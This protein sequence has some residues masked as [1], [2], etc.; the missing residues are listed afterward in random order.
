MGYSIFNV[1]WMFMTTFPLIAR[2]F[3]RRNAPGPTIPLSGDSEANFNLDNSIAPLPLPTTPEHSYL[4]G[5][6][7][8]GLGVHPIGGEPII[9]SATY[10]LT[11][12]GQSVDPRLGG[13]WGNLGYRE[14]EITVSS[15][16]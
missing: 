13:D 12:G 6:G 1:I 3:R 16:T 9:R 7:I 15:E 5:N 2:K 10:S 4:D 11:V 14:T 8:E